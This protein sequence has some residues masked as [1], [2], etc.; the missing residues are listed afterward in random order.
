MSGWWGS[1]RL[2]WRQRRRIG[3]TVAVVGTTMAAGGP[4]V[5]QSRTTSTQSVREN[6]DTFQADVRIRRSRVKSGGG[7][8]GPSIPAVEYHWERVRTGS[9]WKTTVMAKQSGAA[10]VRSLNGLTQLNHPLAAVRMEDDEDGSPL[11][12]YNNRGQ[13]QSSN[14]R[15]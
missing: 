12:F 9:H 10:V 6:W 15:R 3:A 2:V 8:A 14:L 7:A 13:Q 11:R 4:T 1:V 5:A